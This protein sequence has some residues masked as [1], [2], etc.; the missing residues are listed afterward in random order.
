M[1]FINKIIDIL[2]Y[3]LIGII[4][5]I[6]E[7]LPISS[8]GHLALT[9]TYLNINVSSQLDLTMYLHLASSLALCLFFKD[10]IKRIITGFFNYLFKKKSKDDFL[11]CIYLLLASIPIGIVGIFIKPFLES[12]FNNLYFVSFFF[13]ISAILLFSF[14]KIK[15]KVNSSYSIKNTLGVGL[16]QC[17]ALFP[18]LTRSGTTMFA[19]KLFKLD[20]KKQK[21]FSFML[22]LPIS[23]GSLLLSLV[24]I[25]NTS[26]S[27][28]NQTYL[29][30]IAMIV[31]FIMTYLS[32]RLLFNKIKSKH[33]SYFG[34][35]LIFLSLFNLL[36][37]LLS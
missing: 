21:E 1:V 32:L 31:A 22:L 4:Q 25:K 12:Y 7:I 34:I 20:E 3:I 30:I 17:F 35:Y 15:S 27:F 8:S 26:F 16:F 24:D 5:G 10:T 2:K 37:L 23:I 19:A 13:F 28:N 33:F 14:S 29:Y 18:G 11:F 36:I 6:S 9:Y